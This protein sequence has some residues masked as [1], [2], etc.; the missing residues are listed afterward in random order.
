MWSKPGSMASVSSGTL[1]SRSN[2]TFSFDRELR[3]G[4]CDPSGIAYFPSYLNILNGVVEPIDEV[5][6]KLG[7]KL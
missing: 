3:F 7:G 6:K 2:D 4:D 1:L 5:A